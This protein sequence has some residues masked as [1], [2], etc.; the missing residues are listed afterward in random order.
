MADAVSKTASV[1]YYV[2]Q[3]PIS[4]ELQGVEINIYTMNV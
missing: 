2:S 3:P 4:A 1:F